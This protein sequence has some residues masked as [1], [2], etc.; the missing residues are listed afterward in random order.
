M[1]TIG[2]PTS[3]YHYN[4]PD[5]IE[6]DAPVTSVHFSPHCK[7]ILST[8]GPGKSTPAASTYTENLELI[9]NDPIPSPFTN[10]VVVH[11][12]PSLKHVRT[13][14]GATTNIAGS[15]LSPNGQK[16]VLAVPEENKLKIWD[17]WA[18]PAIR[19]QASALSIDGRI[20]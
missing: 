2:G 3:S 4:H 15:L 1:W 16:I 12:Y 18:R 9:E 7:E 11:S 6:F 14:P 10:S 13:L 17:V 5:K 20:R 19:R 8:H